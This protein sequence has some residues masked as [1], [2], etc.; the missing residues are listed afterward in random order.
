MAGGLPKT[1][2]DDD[3]EKLLSALIGGSYELSTHLSPRPS[4]TFAKRT[5]VHSLP[6]IDPLQRDW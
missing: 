2:A 5:C 6:L 1:Y 4:P 3:L